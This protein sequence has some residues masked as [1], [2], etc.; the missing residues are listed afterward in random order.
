[1]EASINQLKMVTWRLDSWVKDFSQPGWEH[2]YGRSPVWILQ[3]KAEAFHKNVWSKDHMNTVSKICF[4]EAYTILSATAWERPRR[5]NKGKGRLLYMVGYWFD[6]SLSV[7]CYAAVSD[8]AVWR[9]SGSRSRCR[10]W[11]R[12][13]CGCAAPG[14]WSWQT[15]WSSE[16]T[17]AV[18]P[19]CGF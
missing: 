19:L 6:L 12:C 11:R 15:I 14:S 5:K 2:L 4:Q 10:V 3:N 1:M 16:D 7:T 13:G 8:W 17:C 9:F 18:C